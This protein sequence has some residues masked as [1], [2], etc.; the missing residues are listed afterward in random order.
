MKQDARFPAQCTNPACRTIF[1][2]SFAA[3]NVTGLKLE[4]NTDRCPVCHR[5]ASVIDGTFDVK[6]AI[7]QVI[8]AP[9]TTKAILAAFL[10][11]AQQAVSGE[12]SEKEAVEKAAAIGPQFKYLMMLAAGSIPILALLAALLQTYLQYDSNRTSPEDFRKVVDAINA[13]TEV[14]QRG[15]QS[16]TP[17]EKTSPPNVTKKSTHRRTQINKERKNRLKARRAELGRSRTR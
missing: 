10:N 3:S 6:D 1:P 13:Q 8:S 4:G 11:V 2:S 5:A 14:L 7:I 17:A 12:I 9:E 16:A 15:I